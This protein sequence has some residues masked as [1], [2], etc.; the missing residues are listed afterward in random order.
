M[1][2]AVEYLLHMYALQGAIYQYDID[3]AI[4]ME[5][6]QYLKMSPYDLDELANE[7]SIDWY[8]EVMDGACGIYKEG[9]Q[10]ALELLT[11]KSEQ[12]YNQTFS[13]SPEIPAS[14]KQTDQ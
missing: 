1:K 13:N 4:E 14:S 6:E 12:Y 9:F 10:K 11:I 7:C 3:K 2:T 5:K 8:G